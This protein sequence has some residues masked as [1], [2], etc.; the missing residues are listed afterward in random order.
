MG[1]MDVSATNTVE[2][3]YSIVLLFGALLALSS[4]IGSVTASMT[5]IRKIKGEKQKK[6]WLLRQY[7]KQRKVSDELRKRIIKYVEHA[8]DAK[9]SQLVEGNVVLLGF[10][11]YQ[12][13]NQLSY[14][15]NA[16]PLL[17]HK[18]FAYMERQ[19]RTVLHDMCHTAI[20]SREVAEHEVVFE[21]GEKASNMY[22]INTGRFQ[23]RECQ[24]QLGRSAFFAEAALWTQWCYR[25]N[26]VCFSE[27]GDLV[28]VM[29]A[30][31]GKVLRSQ[32][33]P[34]AFAKRY[35]EAFVKQL[36]AI[37]IADLSDIM[38]PGDEVL[39]EEDVGTGKKI[40]RGN[41]IAARLAWS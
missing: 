19:M 3:V 9:S 15:V 28:V 22:F 23:Y 27:L 38:L 5:A 37:E 25:G 4:F 16:A 11:S 8:V 39:K 2:R 30:A 6:F 18:F 12:L 1:S 24:Q 29:S 41:S 34:F 35:G 21:N 20:K 33:Q 10:L 13:R 17:V 40:R 31:F 36:S 26:L 7:L 14:E 32:I